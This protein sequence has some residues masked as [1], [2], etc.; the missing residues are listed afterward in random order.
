VAQNG[1]D[2]YPPMKSDFVI[3]FETG[4]RGTVQPATFYSPLASTSVLG[5]VFFAGTRFNGPNSQFAPPTPPF[6]CRSSFDSILYGLGA[7]SGLA[8]YT[9][10]SGEDHVI[11]KD[12]R[13]AA[14]STQAAP[15]G[16]QLGKDEGL[17]K[18]G[19]PRDPPP[20]PGLAPTTQSTQNI[21][22]MSGGGIPQP[23][24]RFGSTVCR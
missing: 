20:A 17:S 16:S 10:P 7:E 14:I 3:E 8:A 18:V 13:L 9:L 11:F 12:S 22:I 24:V 5:R 23:T 2:V 4:F 21:I 19:K 15:Q 6:P 1:I